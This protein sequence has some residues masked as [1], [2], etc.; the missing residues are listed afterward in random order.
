MATM[1]ITVPE[2]MKAFIHEQATKGGFGTVSEYMRAVI[3][4]LQEREDY[5][6]EVREKLLEAVRSGPSTPLTQSDW[7][8]M[9][10]ELRSTSRRAPRTGQ[11][12]ARNPATLGPARAVRDVV[13]IADYLS[14]LRTSLAAGR[15]FLDAVDRTCRRLARMPRIGSRWDDDRSDLAEV[16]FF[17]VTR[18]P[19]LVFYRP[20]RRWY[21]DPSC[22][23]RRTRPA[24]NPARG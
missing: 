10:Q 2:A 8:E 11:W 3:R 20:D 7:D 15:S 16:R 13:E 18:T 23:P 21:R 22:A 1:N 4:D 19:I 6:A 24:A 12:P 17:P 5:R 14:V 9:R